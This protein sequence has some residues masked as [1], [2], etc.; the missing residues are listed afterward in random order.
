M[1]NFMYAANGFAVAFALLAF[2][3][4]MAVCDTQTKL[5]HRIDKLEN[6][7]NNLEISMSQSDSFDDDM[8]SN[9][10]YMNEKLDNLT[11]MV[12][13]LKKQIAVKSKTK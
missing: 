10:R 8:Y 12:K 5:E 6:Q 7:V 3:T 1:K 13:S 11:R 2:V 4:M 9:F